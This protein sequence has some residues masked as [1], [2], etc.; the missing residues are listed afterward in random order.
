MHAMTPTV[1]PA[2]RERLLQPID[3]EDSEAAA[4]DFLA[5]ATLVKERSVMAGENLK[6]AQ[7][8]DTLRYAK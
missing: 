8:R 5:R 3:F 6:V 7:H 2:I 1:P 4:A